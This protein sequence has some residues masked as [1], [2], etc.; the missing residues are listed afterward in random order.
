ME[1]ASFCIYVPHPIKRYSLKLR[2]LLSESGK[3]YKK[4]NKNSK[5]ARTTLR[6][7]SNMQA[8]AAFRATI[9]VGWCPL[10]L[11]HDFKSSVR[12]VA[13]WDDENVF[14]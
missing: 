12:D 11:C 1:V 5:Q 8:Q 2:A 14:A 13:L 3:Y 10:R 9:Q 6:K 4:G 7:P